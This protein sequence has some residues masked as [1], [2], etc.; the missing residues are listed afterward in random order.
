MRA[1]AVRYVFCDA[2]RRL[3]VKLRRTLVEVV[4]LI[5]ADDLKTFDMLVKC[6]TGMSAGINCW[7]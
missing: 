7:R 4:S 6:D 2:V 5:N 1:P 3:W